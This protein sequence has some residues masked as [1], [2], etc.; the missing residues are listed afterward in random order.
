MLDTGDSSALE[1]GAKV[2][3]GAGAT[4]DELR[5]RSSSVDNGRVGGGGDGEEVAV[6]CGV[7]VVIAGK[8]TW[9]G[10]GA[11]VCVG[12][13]IEV[14][15]KLDLGGANSEDFGEPGDFGLLE[16][17]GLGTPELSGLAIPE[18]C[19]LSSPSCRRT[20]V[21]HVWIGEGLRR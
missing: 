10:G 14:L 7:A 6:D 15:E 19:G 11:A 4:V 16:P 21:G 20:R 13:G 9:G 12:R 18:L 8:L 5:G 2:V 17:L 1:D 3:V